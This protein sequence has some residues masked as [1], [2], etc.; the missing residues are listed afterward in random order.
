MP[1]CL[2]VAMCCAVH[3][4]YSWQVFFSKHHGI[5][6]LRMTVL[7]NGLRRR[8]QTCA[9]NQLGAAVNTKPDIQR[10]WRNVQERSELQAAAEISPFGVS[11]MRIPDRAFKLNRTARL[12]LSQHSYRAVSRACC[13]SLGRHGH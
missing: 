5:W 1:V 10:L 11:I 2:L 4:C 12:F 13:S 3:Y 8:V 9:A 7:T 6:P